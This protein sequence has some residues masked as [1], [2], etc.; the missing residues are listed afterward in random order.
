MAG[1][2]AVDLHPP[3]WD[4]NYGNLDDFDQEDEGDAE[5]VQA[6]LFTWSPLGRS[7]LQEV[8]LPCKTLVISFGPQASAF[9]TAQCEAPVVG[10]ILLPEADLLEC[11]TVSDPTCLSSPG[12]LLT[13]LENTV[14]LRQPRLIQDDS[15]SFD[16]VETLFQKVA[17]KRVIILCS[18]PEGAYHGQGPFQPLLIRSLQSSHETQTA[19]VCPNLELPN[20]IGGTPAAV[21][22]HCEVFGLAA[23]MFVSVDSLHAPLVS[24][25]AFECVLP[26]LHLKPK[27]IA[28]YA[29][30]LNSCQL[31]RSALTIKSTLPDSI[32]L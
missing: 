25:E 2:E 4:R 30:F 20:L 17:P 3:D 15:R 11:N 16:W 27:P 12:A 13:M 31:R 19:K 10:G 29:S 18:I 24:V 23:T 9:L 26:A 1:V 22:S 7:K 8:R 28:S 6:P 32:Y 21:L 5:P 14:I